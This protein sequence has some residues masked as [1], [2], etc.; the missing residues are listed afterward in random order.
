MQARQYVELLPDTSQLNL[1]IELAMLTGSFP[2]AEHWLYSTSSNPTANAEDFHAEA[3]KGRSS[4]QDSVDKVHPSKTLSGAIEAEQEENEKNPKLDCCRLVSDDEYQ[5]LNEICRFVNSNLK[6]P[7][8]K[9]ER[10]QSSKYDQRHQYTSHS[11]QSTSQHEPTVIAKPDS[12]TISAFMAAG[13]W[14]PAI[15]FVYTADSWPIDN[16]PSLKFEPILKVLSYGGGTIWINPETLGTDENNTNDDPTNPAVKLPTEV[17][18]NSG[19]HCLKK[20]EQGGKRA[21][22]RWFFERNLFVEFFFLNKTEVERD[23]VKVHNGDMFRLDSA[24][25]GSWRFGF[26]VRLLMCREVDGV[27]ERRRSKKNKSK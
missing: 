3:R 27:F 7:H 6:L 5:K 20:T 18:Q 26:E 17:L 10:S 8:S 21:R 16:D 15:E 2:M 19:F 24:C 23:M 22:Y 11:L 13:P 14:L 1:E 4:L 25:G 12:I 9:K